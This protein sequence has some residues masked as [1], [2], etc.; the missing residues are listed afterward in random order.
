LIYQLL[1]AAVDRGEIESGSV[2]EDL[3][4]I[5]LGHLLYR[6]VVSRRPPTRDSVQMMVDSVIIPC[7]I[8]IGRDAPACESSPSAREIID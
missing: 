4:E 6:T 7:I 2:S 3:A 8:W 5:I 1:T